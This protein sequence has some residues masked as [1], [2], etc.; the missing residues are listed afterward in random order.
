MPSVAWCGHSAD[1]LTC[2]K[3]TQYNRRAAYF[4]EHTRQEL[5]PNKQDQPPAS[6]EERRNVSGDLLQTDGKCGRAKSMVRV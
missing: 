4:N 3:L 1:S 6:G 5:C 2:S